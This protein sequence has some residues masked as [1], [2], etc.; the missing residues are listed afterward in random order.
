MMST[1]ESGVWSDASWDLEVALNSAFLCASSPFF[2]TVVAVDD[3]NN[4]SYVV[5]V[6]TSDFV[7]VSTAHFS[8]C[9]VLY[10][11]HWLVQDRWIDRYGQT[12]TG[13]QH[14]CHI[15]CGLVCLSILV[16]PSVLHKPMLYQRH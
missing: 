15:C 1:A 4:S 7:D 12:D 8:A 2:S 6:R 3:K 14:I 10:I 13:P 11:K 9:A 16:N 5:T